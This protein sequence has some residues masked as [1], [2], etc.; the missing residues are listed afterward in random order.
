MVQKRGAHTWLQVP[1][2]GLTKPFWAGAGPA[3]SLL[4]RE[5]LESQGC[6]RGLL[7]WPGMSR[8]TGDNEGDPPH[9]PH[10]QM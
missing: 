6:L 7:V 1:A 5:K 4:P 8:P 10:P 2:E 9:R 3:V